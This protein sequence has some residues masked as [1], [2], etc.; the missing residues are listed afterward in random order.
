MLFFHIQSFLSSA[1]TPVI[2]S[3]KPVTTL[4]G[5]GL[6]DRQDVHAPHSHLFRRPAQH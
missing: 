1:T 2:D 6:D 4:A 5:Q 3:P